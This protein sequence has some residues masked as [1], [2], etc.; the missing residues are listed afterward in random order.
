MSD[1]VQLFVWFLGVPVAAAIL[2]LFLVA[3]QWAIGRV[4]VAA[5]RYY[6]RLESW[7]MQAAERSAQEQDRKGF[8][9]WLA[10]RTGA[11]PA[12]AEEHLVE[13]Q[14][15]SELIRALIEEEVPKA[16]FRCV[17]THRLTA[18]VTGAF[19]MVEIAYEPECHQ[20]RAG[21]VWLLTHTVALLSA[22]PLRMEDARL[23]HNSIV[24]R[25][26]A[27]STCRRCPYIQLQVEDAP[28]LCPTAEILQQRG[29]NHETTT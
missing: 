27:L 10:A 17:Q 22:Y 24:L 29:T 12:S 21:V 11:N 16:V 20:L 8:L 19:H 5:A 1:M 2:L 3:S 9:R 4:E 13:A 28:R 25:K 26:R 18:K 23:L 7:R 14:Q 15:Q 6:D